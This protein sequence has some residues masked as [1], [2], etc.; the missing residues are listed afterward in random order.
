MKN[1]KEGEGQ[2]AVDHIIKIAD[3]LLDKIVVNDSTIAEQQIIVRTTSSLT[4]QTVEVL[5][6]VIDD[7]R[8]ESDDPAEKLG[9]VVDLLTTLVS[10][11]ETNQRNAEDELIRV[12]AI[13]E[14]M[15]RALTAVRQAGMPSDNLE[16]QSKNET[17]KED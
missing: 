13:Q 14:G 15:R 8:S 9:R 4:T 1:E 2:F 11:L 7:A 6:R 5:R 17:E 3:E 10:S 16:K 12:E